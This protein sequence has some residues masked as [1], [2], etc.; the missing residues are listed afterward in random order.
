MDHTAML[1]VLKERKQGWT[2]LR[3]IQHMEDTLRPAGYSS[4]DDVPLQMKARPP[5]KEETTV[6]VFEDKE[7]F[8]ESDV[9]KE[10]DHVYTEGTASPGVALQLMHNPQ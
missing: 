6:E 3:E 10:Y 1:Q 8:K 4:L 7:Q 2:T 5:T 9:N